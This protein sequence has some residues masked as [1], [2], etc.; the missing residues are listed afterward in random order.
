MP[1]IKKIEIFVSLLL[2]VYCMNLIYFRQQHSK[3]SLF[4]IL[5]KIAHCGTNFKILNNNHS[6]HNLLDSKS[7]YFRINENS[8]ELQTK[9]SEKIGY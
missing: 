9:I 3:V 8:V 7:N 6:E 1:I 2:T 4:Y 5:F